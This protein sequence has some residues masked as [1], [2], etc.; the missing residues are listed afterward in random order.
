MNISRSEQRVLHVLAQGG[1]VRHQRADNG[2]ILDVL[3]FTRDGHV[4]AD[5][6]LEVFVKLRR[7]RLI[8]SKASSPYRISDKGRRSVRA[9]LDNR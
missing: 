9:Q 3:C 8:E 5:C 7:K 4:L 2:R 6:T 1:Y